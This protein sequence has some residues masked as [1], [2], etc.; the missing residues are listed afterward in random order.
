MQHLKNQGNNFLCEWFLLTWL[1]V[2]AKGNW[3]EREFWER[4]HTY[5]GGEE[6]CGIY[7]GVDTWNELSMSK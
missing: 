2:V 6:P 7:C 5:I 3:Q 4:N 1:Y